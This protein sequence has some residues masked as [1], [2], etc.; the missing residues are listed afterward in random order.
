MCVEHCWN[1]TDRVTEVLGEK[2]CLAWVE[3]E[4]MCVVQWWNGTERGKLKCWGRI[5][6]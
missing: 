1:G 3:G 2:H 6:M 5:I 4:L